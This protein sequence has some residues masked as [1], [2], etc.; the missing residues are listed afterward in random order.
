[1]FDLDRNIKPFYELAQTEPILQN[2]V[3]NY[4]GYRVIGIPNLFESLTWAIIGQQINLTFAYTLKKRF[5]EQFGKNI[6]WQGE[7]Y[8]MFP[9]YE[10]IAKLNIEDLQT[11]QFSQRK[12]E[13]IIGIAKLFQYG[14]ICKERISKLKNSAIKKQIINNNG[15]GEWK[16]KDVKLR[17]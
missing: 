3:N 9:E 17:T 8:W 6:V 16:A 10:Q 13:Y 14:T 2:L 1:M 5:T 12:A 11:L 4:Y 15:S 7:K